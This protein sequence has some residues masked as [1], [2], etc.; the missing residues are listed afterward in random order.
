M[1]NFYK[2]QYEHMIEVNKNFSDKKEKALNI[3]TSVVILVVFPILNMIKQMPIFGYQLA[4]YVIFTILLVGICFNLIITLKQYAKRHYEIEIEDLEKWRKMVE[5]YEQKMDK[6][7]EKTDKKN[8][9]SLERMKEKNKRTIIEQYYA[10]AYNKMLENYEK[11]S[12]SLDH[13]YWILAVNIA[14]ELILAILII[15]NIIFFTN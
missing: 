2:S 9:E 10:A 5:T 8:A 15:I 13:Y 7:I 3:F 11:K 4:A 14:I 1:D 12:K 6:Q